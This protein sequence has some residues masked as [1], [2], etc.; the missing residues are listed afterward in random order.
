MKSPSN[1]ISVVVV[2]AVIASSLLLGGCGEGLRASDIYGASLG[3]AL[4][5]GIIGYQSHE[6][7]EGAAIGAA[8][9]G[10]GELLNQIDNPKEKKEHKD[11][12]DNGCKEVYVIQ[13]HNSNGSVTPIEVEKKGDTYIG[14][15][16]EHYEQL[17][18]EEQ[19]KPVYGF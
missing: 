15:K 14:P 4:V 10:V 7:G 16:G 19:L 11:K 1:K 18:T 8:L 2:A 13:V 5:G 9:F 6:E 3:G 12:D 17:P